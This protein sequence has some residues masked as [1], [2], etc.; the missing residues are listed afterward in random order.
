MKRAFDL[1]SCLFVFLL[2]LLLTACEGDGGGG[3]RPVTSAPSG[4]SE[5][6]ATTLNGVVA[7]GYLSGARVFLDRNGNRTYDSGEPMAISGSGGVF[8]LSINPGEGAKYSVVVEVIGGETVDEDGGQAVTDSYLLEAPAG[9]WQFVS[10]L[11]TLVNLEMKKN[12]GTKLQK[13]ELNVKRQLAIDDEISLFDDYLAPL[14]DQMVEARRTHK[15]AQVVAALMGTLRSAIAANLGGTIA[16]EE[17]Q[18][19]AYLVSDE[20]LRHGN[21]IAEGL[22]AERNLNQP[23]VVASLKSSIGGQ[24]DP[25]KLNRSNLQRY[26]ERIAQNLET[27]DMNP[28]QVDQQNIA[29]GAVV[30]V[31]VLVTVVFDKGIDPAT[32]SANAISLRRADGSYVSGAVDYD[33]ELK[34]LSFIPNQMLFPDTDYEAVISGQLADYLGNQIGTDLGWQF[35]T[36][37]DLTPPPLAEIGSE[38]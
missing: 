3:L 11:T 29:D 33:A 30:S 26:A 17:Q 4:T 37:F 13:A 23:A 2:L 18:P 14:P 19:V 27:W 9:H 20:I 35:S 36:L 21:V 38:Q 5:A 10:P 32:I 16:P 25:S 8:T 22:N 31:D 34:R 12:P 28:P 15:A 6:A 1:Y 7:D 24:V